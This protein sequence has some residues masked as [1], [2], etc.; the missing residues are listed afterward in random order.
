MF[1]SARCRALACCTPLKPNLQILCETIVDRPHDGQD[2]QD[3]PTAND[4]PTGRAGCSGPRHAARGSRCSVVQAAVPLR[5]Q[6]PTLSSTGDS[7]RHPSGLA[8]R[9][10]RRLRRAT[11]FR[12]GAWRRASCRCSGC[13]RSSRC[14]SATRHTLTTTRR[15]S[16]RPA[17]PAPPSTALP[18]LYST[19]QRYTLYSF[20][21][22][23]TIHAIHHLT[24]SCGGSSPRAGLVGR[25]AAW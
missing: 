25:G 5:S 19:T 9:R 2:G 20:T 14:R 11:R 18:A 7:A 6:R 10:A 3:S 23:Y 22:L 12:S 15:V 17:A 21:A 8:R 1:D 4:Q 16:P 13:T 24:R